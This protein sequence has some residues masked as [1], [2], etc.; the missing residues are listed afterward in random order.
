ML[1]VTAPGA[2]QQPLPRGETCS[3]APPV[4]VADATEKEK[5][6]PVLDMLRVCG[7]GFAPAKGMVKLIGF[8]WLKTESPTTTATGTVTLLP[9]VVNVSSPTKV[10]GVSPP[11]GKLAGVTVTARMD[12]AVPDAELTASQ[13]PPSTVVLDAV[14]G[15]DPVPLLRICNNWK[16]GAAPPVFR[17]KLIWPGTLSKNGPA[18]ATVSVTVMFM[19]TVAVG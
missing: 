11:P 19:V 18:E 8:T 7:S 16:G 5:F 17:E 14:Q 12:G 10:P 13:L 1:T 15:R 4:A 6:D 3:Q 2:V 9:V